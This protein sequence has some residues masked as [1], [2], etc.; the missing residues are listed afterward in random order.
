M[1]NLVRKTRAESLRMR[2]RAREKG[3]K[4]TT[5]LLFPAELFLDFDLLLFSVVLL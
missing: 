2:G 1:N 5:H 3:G 4:K